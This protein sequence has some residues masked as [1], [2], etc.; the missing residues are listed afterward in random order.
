MACPGCGLVEEGDA[1]GSVHAY[2]ST[3]AVCWGLF[4][5]LLAELGPEATRLATDAYA[6]QHPFGREDDR[7]QRQSVAVHLTALCLHVENRVREKQL[8]RM[9]TSLSRLVLP[10]LEV[11]E[12]P[13]LAS[14]SDLGQ[15]TVGDVD[16]AGPEERPQVIEEWASSVWAAWAEEHDTVRGWAALALSAYGR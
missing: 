7:R 14:P 15:V 10:R 6:A 13:M 2:M 4:S 16:R 8:R 9:M 12:W 3:G 5:Q 11:P 1:S